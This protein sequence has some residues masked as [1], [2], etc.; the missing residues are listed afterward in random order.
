LYTA[1]ALLFG[2][3]EHMN[4][5]RITAIALV[6]LLL[7]GI[8]HADIK[9]TFQLDVSEWQDKPTKVAVAGSFNGWNKE[10]TLMA[11]EG[12]NL[13]KVVVDLPEGVHTYKF[14]IDGER[15]INDP[16]A[17]PALDADDT[18]GGR[19]SG[20]LVGPDARKFPD[21][22]PNLI[23]ADGLIHSPA[24]TA[25]ASVVDEKQL[26]LR[27]RTQA[28]DVEQVRVI[29]IDQPKSDPV[30][31]KKLT[32]ERGFDSWGGVVPIEKSPARYI[33]EFK[34]GTRTVYMGAGGVGDQKA[35]TA[36]PFTMPMKTAFVTP[37]W[38]KNAVWYQIFPE[39]FRN[40]DPSND[41][42]MHWFENPVAWTSRWFDVLP[43]ETGGMENFYKLNVWNRRYGGD[44][45]GIREKLPYLRKLGVTAIYLNPIFEAES[46][47]KY[48]TSD[49]RHIDDN[50]GVKG[51]N[52][53]AFR[54]DPKDPPG[55]V[56]TTQALPLAGETD[57]PAT[58]QWTA[59]DRVFLDFVADAHR[60]GFKV[61][62][63]GVFNHVGRAHPFFQD[64]LKNGK[65]SK[66]ADWFEITDWGDPTNWRAMAD[67]MEV[68]GK[69]GGIQWKAWDEPNG[70]LPVFRKDAEKGLAPGP[71][72]HI[73]AITKRWLAPDG[74]RSRGV[75][76]FRL[77]VANDIPHGFWRD[78]RKVVKTANPDA[79]IAGEIWSPA[80]PWL[81]GDEFDGVMNY[82]F[83]VAAQDFFVNRKNAL[84]PSQFNARLV[85]LEYM[86]P[87]QA[88]L[89]Q[90][91]LF[92]SHDTDRF[93]SMFVNPDRPYDGANRLQDNGLTYSGRKPNSQEWARFK[94]A[95][96]LQMT[97]VGA[98]MIYYG[99]EAGMWSPDDPSNRQPMVWE[100][101]TFD[102]PEVG[103]NRE[104]FDHHRRLIAVR[105]YLPALRTGNYSPVSINDAAGVLVFARSLPGEAPVY[106]AINRSDEARTV[107]FDVQP[108]QAG[109]AVINFLDPQQA[110]L[111]EPAPDAAD[112]R[113]RIAVRA[114][115][116]PITTEGTTLR[117]SL[118]PY[119]SAVLAEK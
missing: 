114:E 48:D 107:T 94:Q 10:A 40:G 67:P 45:Q 100:E 117:I 22:Q 105:Q 81:A 113:S 108:Q 25:D 97:F 83:A 55:R 4:G 111:I 102:D 106:V 24:N 34:D 23:N 3:E 69:P 35:A 84:L 47:H 2:V 20:V 29:L 8:A 66:Y 72:T 42:N 38:A 77:D 89:A 41:P 27:V 28:N 116:Q 6:A 95:V 85:Q 14:V 51:D 74:D 86:Y 61:V 115:A 90:M 63:D 68:H 32:D 104:I 75:D 49:Y 110:Q 87:F 71:Y 79:Y 39:R 52:P 15:W 109:K 82:Q 80:Q 43:G 58:W 119:G 60:Q 30:V 12:D 73:M 17:D 5:R 65:N 62:L 21:A 56:P 16:K 36:K 57:D 44:I 26:R 88:V 53:M 112:A 33:L 19:N 46:M 18:F 50:F 31:L 9:Q 99:N 59:S 70:H 96:A 1:V 91:N 103:F 118:A 92:D 37:D 64:V 54:V 13:W 93:A 11:K 101:M 98:P 78:W 7:A 76:G